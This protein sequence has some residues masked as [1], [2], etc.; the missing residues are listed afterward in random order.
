MCVETLRTMFIFPDTI[1]LR[2]HMP[3]FS[4]KINVFPPKS[5]ETPLNV[6]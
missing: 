1:N 6:C 2:G 5:L 3:R 4:G